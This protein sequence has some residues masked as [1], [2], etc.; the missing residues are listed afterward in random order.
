MFQRPR[1]LLFAVT[2]VSAAI[3]AAAWLVHFATTAVDVPSSARELQVRKGRSLAGLSNDLHA[4]GVFAEPWSFLW[5]GRLLGRASDIQAGYYVLPPR[6][7]PYRLLEMIVNGEVTEAQITFI[8]GWTFAQLRAALDASPLLEHDSAGMTEREILRRIGADEVHPEGLFFP[9][10][11]RF[12]PGSSDLRILAQAYRTMRARLQGLWQARAPGLPYASQYQALIMASIVEKESG[13]EA[14][15]TMIAAVF[16]NRLRRQMRL[17]T[18]PSVIYGLGPAF[19]GNLRRRDLEADTPYNTYTRTGLPPTPIALPGQGAL[20]AALQPAPSK[21][22]YF[23][24]RGDGSSHFSNNL[25]DHNRA[26]RKF[27]LGR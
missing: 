16:I 1:L 3:A 27:Q 26:V 25:S 4:A 21:A 20:E 7:T 22:L 13:R 8:E 10:T 24:A 19:D 12:A 23:V 5:M 2:M 17:Q 11:Y 15:R 14:D 9:D 6:I 18:D